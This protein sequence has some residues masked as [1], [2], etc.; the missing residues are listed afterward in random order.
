MY[1]VEDAEEDLWEVVWDGEKKVLALLSLTLPR[2]AGEGPGRETRRD[3]TGLPLATSLYDLWTEES[4]DA[5]TT[6]VLGLG[7]GD[8]HNWSQLVEDDA[9]GGKG[10]RRRLVFYLAMVNPYL[11]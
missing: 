1:D 6:N 10:R 8:G 9:S 5:M 2:R 11:G 4:G 3:I 7:A